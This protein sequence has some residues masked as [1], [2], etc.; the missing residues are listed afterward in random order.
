MIVAL[1]VGGVAITRSLL[2]RY[3]DRP[4]RLHHYTDW[5]SLSKIEV[6]GQIKN[7]SGKPNFYS[8]DIVPDA[9]DAE[10]QFAVCKRLEVRITLD[11][12]YPSDG[13]YWEPRKVDEKDCDSNSTGGWANKHAN[14]GK[15]ETSTLKG[16]PYASRRPI[17]TPLLGR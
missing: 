9:D 4:L 11:M 5:E 7:P 17:N 1:G 16:I 14:G 13:F 15:K 2:E 12:Y 6:S 10:D 8:P 3:R